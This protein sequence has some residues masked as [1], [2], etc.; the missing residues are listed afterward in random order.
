VHLGIEALVTENADG[1]YDPQLGSLGDT[2]ERRTCPG[3]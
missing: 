2:L 3:R 1:L